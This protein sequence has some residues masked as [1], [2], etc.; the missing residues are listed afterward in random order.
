MMK[1]TLMLAMVVLTLICAQAAA[2][3]MYVGVYGGAT[4]VPDTDLKGKG[5]LAGVSATDVSFDTGGTVGGKIGGWCKCLPYVG[6]EGNIWSTWS[7][8]SGPAHVSGIGT[9]N[10]S[11]DINLLNFSGSVLIQYPT[12]FLRP[13]A[14]AGFLVSRADT[15]GLMVNGSQFLTSQDVVSLGFMAQ[16]GVEGKVTDQF[17]LFGEY[18]YTWAEYEFDTVKVDAPTHNFLAGV[19]LHF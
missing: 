1:K 2:A 5:I 9:V 7:S 10:L 6:F 8:I 11:S 19:A 4:V 3:E 16:A 17:G 12:K 15:N 18:R 13:Y 14:G